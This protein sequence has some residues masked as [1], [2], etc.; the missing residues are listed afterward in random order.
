MPRKE[1]VTTE[2]KREILW[3]VINAFILGGAVF[4]GAFI[5]GQVSRSELL[6]SFGAAVILFLSKMGDYWKGEKG[7]YSKVGAFL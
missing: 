1:L 5:D 4:F 6:A 2:N 3:N 7:E